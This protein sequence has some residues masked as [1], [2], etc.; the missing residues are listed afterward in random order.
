[1]K[2]LWISSLAW[3]FKNGYIHSVNSAGAVSGSLFEQEIIDGME[4]LGNHVNIVCS[5]PYSDSQ[6]HEEFEW[7]H[8]QVS[9]DFTIKQKKHKIINYL[10]EFPSFAK[11]INRYDIESYDVVIVYLIHTPFLRLLKKIKKKYSNIQTLLICPDLSDMMDLNTNKPFKRLLKRAE[12]RILVNYY[13]YVDKYVLFSKHMVEHIPSANNKYIV[14]EGV[15]SIRDSNRFS[16][17]KSPFIVMYAGSL[18]P[19]F[20][21][22]NL[23]ESIDIIADDEVQ[24][25]IY[26]SGLLEEQIK[27]CA[28]KKNNVSF[29]GFLNHDLIIQKEKEASLLVIPRD[30]NEKYTRYSFP[31]KL[32]EY[33]MSGTPVLTTKLDGI[34]E[35]YY[36]FL[37][38]MDKNSPDAIASAI[39]SIRK[40]DDNTIMERVQSGQEY[41]LKQKNNIVQSRAILD[42]LS[43]DNK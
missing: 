27:E 13:K 15:N 25:H 2:I 1:M 36:Q 10:F 31:S 11:A 30:S 43:G 9:N 5:F 33:I 32:F 37:F 40:L 22:E 6:K 16:C 38:L 7:S 20:G 17:K 35:E 29:F 34:P 8:N 12:K 24:L 26:G 4:K 41:L 3:K 39:C 19:C 18:Q 23:I 28:R 14:V 42:F 21:L